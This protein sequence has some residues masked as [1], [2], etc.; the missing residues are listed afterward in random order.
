[1][2]KALKKKKPQSKGSGKDSQC[3]LGGYKRRKK[4]SQGGR[5]TSLSPLWLCRCSKM[6]A[7]GSVKCYSLG[8][9]RN[10]NILLRIKVKSS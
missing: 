10:L 8:C 5:I 9:G 6:G 1:M 4:G 7:G 2:Q 3:R